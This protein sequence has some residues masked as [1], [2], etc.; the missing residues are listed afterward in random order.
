[1]D[2][3]YSSAYMYD[4]IFIH[5]SVDGQLAYFHVLVIINSAAMNIGVHVSFWIML[6]PRSGIDGTYGSFIFGFLRNFHAVIV[7][8]LG[9][10]DDIYCGIYFHMLTFTIDT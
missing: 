4:I 1:M 3:W 2:E 10:P 5:S 7:F 9:F 6:M 8:N